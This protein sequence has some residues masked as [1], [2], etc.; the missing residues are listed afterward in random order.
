MGEDSIIKVYNKIKLNGITTDLNL[1]GSTADTKN[2][3]LILTSEGI[4]TS[5]H[6]NPNLGKSYQADYKLSGDKKGNWLQFKLENMTE[7][8][9]SVGVIFRRKSTK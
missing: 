2:K 3:L 6:S 8:L 1:G 9:D 5:T 7:P 4:P